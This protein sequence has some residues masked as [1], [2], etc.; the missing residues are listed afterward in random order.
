M[1]KY[2]D[3][4][5]T[6]NNLCNWLKSISYGNYRN[7]LIASVRIKNL[8]NTISEVKSSNTGSVNK[9]IS[10]SLSQR[11]NLIPNDNDLIIWLKN[12][13]SGDFRACEFAANRISELII[14]LNKLKT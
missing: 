5:K 9:I 10:D 2:S 8:L 4:I 11:D 14:E 3:I 13:S 6:D 12:N 1:I 7:C